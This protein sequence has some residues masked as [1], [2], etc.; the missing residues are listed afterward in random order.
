M[1]RRG[2]WST[3]LLLLALPA[4]IFVPASPN[5]SGKPPSPQAVDAFSLDPDQGGLTSTVNRQFV[6]TSDA[7]QQTWSNR[8]PKP[9]EVT[10]GTERALYEAIFAFH[11]D[12]QRKLTPG[13]VFHLAL[14]QRRG[15]AKEAMLLAHNTHDPWGGLRPP[16]WAAAVAPT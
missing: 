6:F 12:N 3:L 9:A 15:D 1:R 2:V 7:D 13:D 16:C 11:R 5:A 4:L 14:Q 8:I 10:F